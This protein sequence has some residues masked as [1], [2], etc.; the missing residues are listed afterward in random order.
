MKRNAWIELD[1]GVF[2]ENLRALQGALAAGTQ[3]V[4]VVKAN[5]YGHGMTAVARQACASGVSW[6]LVSRMDEAVELRQALPDVHILL[7]GAAWPSDI[8]ELTAHRITPVLV[9]EEQS[10]AL[11]TEACR[12]QVTLGCHA[13]IDTGMG[14]LG[15]AW[16]NAAQT[17]ARLKKAGG[18]AIEGL[19]THFASAGRPGDPFAALQEDRFR[20]VVDECDRHGLEGLFKHISNSAAFG[21]HAPWDLDGVRLGIVAYGYGKASQKRAATH[22]FLQWKSRVVQ[23]KSVPAG[24]PVSYLGTHVTTAPTWLATVDVGYS[25]GFPRLL[26]NKGC[27][28]VG[29]RRAPVVGRV[30]MNFITVDVGPEGGVRSGDEVVLIGRQGREA[31]WADELARWCQTIPYEILTNIRSDSVLCR[32]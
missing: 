17:L 8:D 22:P 1:L 12:R 5:A 11:A 31:L 30:T 19:A 25:D 20:Q 4:L 2:R 10:G 21:V 32:E 6:F 29:G 15:F 7:L 9:S 28:L 3:I 13:K 24:F 23:V 16:E 18:L 26:S 14:R 27:V